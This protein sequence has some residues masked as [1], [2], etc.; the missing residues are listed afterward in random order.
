MTP[1]L[2]VWIITQYNWRAAFV[3]FGMMGVLWAVAWL[4]YYR[5]APDEHAGANLAERDLI[6][7]ATGGAQRRVGQPFRGEKFYRAPASGIWPE[8]I[9]ATTIAS[10]LISIGSPRIFINIAVTI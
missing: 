9:S 7:S 10:P 4:V 3:T 2:V 6:R 5:D 1:P 8:C